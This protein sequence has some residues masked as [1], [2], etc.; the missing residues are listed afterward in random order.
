MKGFIERYDSGKG[1][2][3]ITSQEGDDCFFLKG[4]C[5]RGLFAVEFDVEETK[6]G[7]K[8]N[9]VRKVIKEDK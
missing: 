4:E 2:G 9:N 1:Y 8:A 7:L 3:F 5:E 6:K